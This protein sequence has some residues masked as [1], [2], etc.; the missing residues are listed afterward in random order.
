M[1]GWAKQPEQP[2]TAAPTTTDNSNNAATT[3]TTS[4]VAGDAIAAAN[5]AAND[6]PPADPLVAAPIVNDN[7]NNSR[8]SEAEDNDNNLRASE[9]SDGSSS[10]STDAAEENAATPEVELR[11]QKILRKLHQNSKRIP[12]IFA[13]FFSSSSN[14]AGPGERMVAFTKSAIISGSL[15]VATNKV[16]GRAKTPLQAMAALT[17]VWAGARFVKIIFAPPIMKEITVAKTLDY[18]KLTERLQ[19]CLDLQGELQDVSKSLDQGAD[20]RDCEPF[21]AK[22]DELLAAIAN[23][24]SMQGNSAL[25]I[26]NPK[27][28]LKTPADTRNFLIELSQTM[29]AALKNGSDIR[30]VLKDRQE[31]RTITTEK[32][33]TDLKDMEKALTEV[34]QL[35]SEEA[36]V[37]VLEAFVKALKKPAPAPK[38]HVPSYFHARYLAPLWAKPASVEQPRPAVPVWTYPSIGGIVKQLQA[39]MPKAAPADQQLT[40]ND[41]GK[42]VDAQGRVFNV[43]INAANKAPVTKITLGD[44]GRHYDQLGRLVNVRT[45]G[46]QNPHRR[47]QQQYP[48]NY[49]PLNRWHS[50]NDG[51]DSD[52]TPHP[53][54]FGE[55][56]GAEA[57]SQHTQ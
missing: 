50:G 35:T 52:G 3:A 10:T 55:F 6:S 32:C 2:T 39:L 14:A 27:E 36:Q 47:E 33:N 8:A 4:V 42:L 19:S 34:K 15:F 46:S 43:D 20:E 21:N 49:T 29:L 26:T 12:T 17:A 11:G 5:T 13:R 56:R 45:N 48:H 22:R 44:D 24:L 30:E 1:G 53:M 9:D 38:Q 57:A 23:L 25:Q 18:T 16:Q 51:F 7:D 41:K 37:K 40:L 31:A 54:H 28:C